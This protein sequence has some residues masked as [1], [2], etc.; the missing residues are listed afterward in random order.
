[1]KVVR[2]TVVNCS[3]VMQLDKQSKE[4]GVALFLCSIG[5]DVVNKYNNFDLSEQNCHNFREIIK[6]FDNDA[7]GEANET[8]EGYIQ[9]R[10]SN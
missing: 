8:Y 5:A 4:F 9:Q 2:A 7:T 6:A 3:I 1:M 10:R